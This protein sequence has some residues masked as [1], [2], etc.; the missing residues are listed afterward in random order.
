ML[1]AV[2]TNFIS[3]TAA[4]ALYGSIFIP[5]AVQVGFNPASMAILIANV[6]LGLVFP[7]AGAASATAFSVGEIE[8]GRMIKVGIVATLVF[9][10]LTATVHILMA[11]FV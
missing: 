10:I 4:T 3:G 8:M 9:A 6:S 11:P 2:T 7:W 1:A 5:A